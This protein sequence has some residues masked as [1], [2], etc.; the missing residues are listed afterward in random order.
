MQSVPNT[1]VTVMEPGSLDP[2]TGERVGDTAVAVG[3]PAAI[4][5]RPATRPR[6]GS[7]GRTTHDPATTTPRIVRVVAGRVPFGTPIAEGT[8]LIDE[9]SGK[10]YAVKSARQH[11]TLRADPDIILELIRNSPDPV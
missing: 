6:T 11:E 2:E 5:E 3:V 9:R 7:E 4:L 8:I 10:V 1:A